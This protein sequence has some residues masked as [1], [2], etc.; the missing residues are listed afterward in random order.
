MEHWR[1]AGDT[2]TVMGVDLKCLFPMLFWAF[3]PFSLTAFLLALS[4][5]IFFIVL[6]FFGFPLV[7]FLRWFRHKIRGKV[8]EPEGWLY[9]RRYRSK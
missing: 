2:P 9:W 8:V 1:Y 6:S 7:V 4:A 3:D 5:V